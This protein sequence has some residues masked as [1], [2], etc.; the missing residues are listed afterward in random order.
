MR[1]KYTDKMQIAEL[2]KEIEN[3]YKHINAKKN[4]KVTKSK[5]L[6]I[7]N[8]TIFV[9][10]F[11]ILCGILTSVLI[12]KSSGQ[13]PAILGYQ[14]YVVQSG[15]MEPTFNVGSVILSKIPKD[16]SKLKKGD[17]V[18]FTNESTTITHR[19]V[20]VINENGVVK[21]KTKG[22]NPQNSED[23]NLLTPNRVIAVFVF[24]IPLI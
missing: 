20:A 7:I 22:D 6:R 9:V 8:L 1:D 24:R 2:Q 16:A 21:Y 15:S 18:T 10:L 11:I 4:G 3:E 23:T 5:A 17:V 13:T 12:A 14:L 19:I